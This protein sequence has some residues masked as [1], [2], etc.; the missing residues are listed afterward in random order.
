MRAAIAQADWRVKDLARHRG[1]SVRGVARAFARIF[2][3][4]PRR[5]INRWRLSEAKRRMAAGEAAKSVG[6]DLGF[7]DA[8]HSCHWFKAQAGLTPGQFLELRSGEGRRAKGEGR[9]TPSWASFGEN[10][11]DARLTDSRL[12]DA[13][14]PVS[15]SV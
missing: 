4:S 14:W 2:G 11:S 12:D 13:P 5:R 8:A 7:N 15:E 9:A 10:I 1:T 6:R 3:E